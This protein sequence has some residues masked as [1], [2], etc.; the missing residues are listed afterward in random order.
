MEILHEEEASERML[1][2]E[3]VQR[4][5]TLNYSLPLDERL[6]TFSFETSEYLRRA[7]DTSRLEENIQS[8]PQNQ[9]R[10]ALYLNS[11][12]YL[13]VKAA[14]N[15]HSSYPFNIVTWHLG[16]FALPEA[17]ASNAQASI[18]KL[19]NDEM[20]A[21]GLYFNE[22]KRANNAGVLH[23][24]VEGL[25]DALEHVESVVFYVADR[26]FACAE[27]MNNLVGSKRG[28]GELDELTKKPFTLWGSHHVLIVATLHSLFI[29]G[30]SIK[31]EEFNGCNLYASRVYRRI[32][33]LR[34]D[35]ETALG[36]APQS[37]LAYSDSPFSLARSVARLSDQL[38][39]RRWL[40]Y[41]RVSGLTLQKSERL[42]R[43]SERTLG[44]IFRNDIN[45]VSSEW[46]VD[47]SKDQSET[48][49]FTTLVNHAIEAR[50]SSGSG[51]KL[52]ALIQVV[53]KSAIFCTKADYSM[54]S[55]LRAP[56]LLCQDS[57]SDIQENLHQLTPKHF[58][59]EIASSSH[60]ANQKADQLIQD[61][62]SPVQRRME[63]N[64][65]HFVVGNLPR[66]VIH[67]S[68]HYFFPPVLPDISNYSSMSHAAHNKADVRFAIRSP[69]PDVSE[70]PLLLF[71][72][73]YWGFYDCRVVRVSGEPFTE[74]EL[75]T[76]RA[77][78]QMIGV[79]WRLV[80]S[81]L[82]NG[83]ELRTIDVFTEAQPGNG[84]VHMLDG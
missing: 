32:A 62:F 42:I 60:L 19:N 33:A 36:F 63:F 64:R 54:S 22:L 12:G 55:S 49:Q 47:I 69:G 29:T 66:S 72:L 48:S 37:I 7:V 10:F 79:I 68:R 74:E 28:I 1:S 26:I 43:T 57:T 39:G 50:I 46:S 6:D 71:G 41:R 59:C 16:D 40:R 20:V 8:N 2:P 27:R 24:I 14:G 23:H 18:F 51:S 70:E 44:P 3:D 9:R 53:L 17:L 76:V 83:V 30:K 84:A 5:I 31:F 81:H 73:P 61:I 78:S 21:Q 25:I 75:I 4:I 34:S 77:H 82:S 38:I 13:Q 65:W 52:S 45:R 35:Y 67:R 11:L 15:S 56:G 80:S 58:F